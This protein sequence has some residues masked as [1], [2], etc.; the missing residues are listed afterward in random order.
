ML[1]DIARFNSCA[2]RMLCEDGDP[3]V[4]EY[5]RREG[6]SRQFRDNYLLVS[7]LSHARLWIVSSVLLQPLTAAVWN[8][9]PDVC[10]TD[11]PA[12]NVGRFLY[13]H[14]FM[15]IS[16]KLTWLTIRGGR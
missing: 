14:D 5:L 4:G 13:N 10:A 16:R 6:Y 2:V 15:R 12:K 11:S 8:T 7:V 3:T 1:F 9:L